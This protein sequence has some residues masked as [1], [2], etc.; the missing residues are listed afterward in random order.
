MGVR[1]R[2][3][4]LH[5]WAST[6]VGAGALGLALSACG[7]GYQ[8]LSH[9]D[10]NGATAFFKLPSGWT[11]FD[12]SQVL[13][14][15]NG[16][17]SR[18]QISQLEGGAW[19]TSF[20]G[21]SHASVSQ[22]GDI[23]GPAPSGVTAVRQLS[24]TERD[25]FSLGSLRSAILGDDPLSP[26]SGAKKFQ[27]LSYNEFTKPGGLRGSKMVVNVDVGGG[28]L[29][30][31]DQVAMVDSGTKYLYLIALGCRVSCY[32]AN[33]GVIDQVV[34]SWTVKENPAS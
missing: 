22:A 11:L 13:Q 25:Q 23:G 20:N 15:A 2:R 29:A 26:S 18:Q 7:S 19:S 24:P 4:R 21:A 8:Y 17:L 27:V 10:G 1:P 6:L 3:T 34:Q 16:P 12:Q 30:S 9:R 31:L 5:P 32:S 28:T 14:A 33:H